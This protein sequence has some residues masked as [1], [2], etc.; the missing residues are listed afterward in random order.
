MSNNVV[1]VKGC[2]IVDREMT[3]TRYAI[4]RANERRRFESFKSSI[5]ARLIFK[6]QSGKIENA[7]CQRNY[8]NIFL[9]GKPITENGC[10]VFATAQALYGANPTIKQV[11]EIVSAIESKDYY[12][13]G[14]GVWWHWFSNF[15][16]RAEHWQDVLDAIGNGKKVVVLLNHD[17]MKSERNHFAT[18]VGVLANKRRL[19]LTK[20]DK[21]VY[22][23]IESVNKM[24][25]ASP[26]IFNE[27]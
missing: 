17:Y 4:Y 24:I 5:H 2:N 21:L 3:P 22:I 12:Y 13:P 10:A 9:C 26:W 15:A 6:V 11:Q 7:I 16:R 27:G 25:V 20:G 23:P 18:I 1:V 8:R 14:R 19:V